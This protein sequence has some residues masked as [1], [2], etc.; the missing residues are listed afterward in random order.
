VPKGE[1]AVELLVFCDCKPKNAGCTPRSGAEKLTLIFAPKTPVMSVGGTKKNANLVSFATVSA[2]R[3]AFSLL[4][5][6]MVS[7]NA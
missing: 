1:L 6:L 3:I 4:T 2:C 7:P 5:M